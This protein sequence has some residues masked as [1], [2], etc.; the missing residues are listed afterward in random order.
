[1][2]LTLGKGEHALFALA[3]SHRCTQILLAKDMRHH[4]SRNIIVVLAHLLMVVGC[5]GKGSLP[6][7]D[8]VGRDRVPQ[9]S[10]SLYT[11]E[12]AKAVYDYEP[13]RAMV[14]IDSAE[15]VGNLTCSAPPTAMPTL[16][17]WP[18]VSWSVPAGRAQAL[19]PG[20]Q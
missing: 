14:I 15:I 17:P 11:E 10:D 6:F 13:E 3:H 16:S 19:F 1:M 7:G 4:V 18:A 9:A 8:G 20:H 5:T 2:M 12:A